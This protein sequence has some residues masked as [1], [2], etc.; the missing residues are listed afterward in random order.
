MHVSLADIHY[1]NMYPDT[2]T[3]KPMKPIILLSNTTFV[4]APP[5]GVVGEAEAEVIVELDAEAC[6][7]ELVV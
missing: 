3:A 6:P 4:M 7:V 2:A 5:V 1:A